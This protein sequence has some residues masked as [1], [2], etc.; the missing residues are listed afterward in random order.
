MLVFQNPL[1]VNLTQGFFY[2]FYTATLV[3]VCHIVGSMGAYAHNLTPIG[4][5]EGD[6][7]DF[8]QSIISSVSGLHFCGGPAAIFRRIG[9]VIVDSIQGVFLGGA[10]PHISIKSREV[11]AP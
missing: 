1:V 2:R 8:Y 7:I 10:R 4:N 3:P 11:V 9:A 6:A 5:A